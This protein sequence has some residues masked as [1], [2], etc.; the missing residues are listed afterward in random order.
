MAGLEVNIIL[1]TGS[2]VIRIVIF[3]LINIKY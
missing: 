3:K 2:F 1:F